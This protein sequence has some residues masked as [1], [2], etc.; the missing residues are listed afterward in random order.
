MR[1]VG[2]AEMR[3]I[4][5]AAIDGLGIPSLELMERAGRAAADAARGLAGPGGRFAV[6][7]GGGNNGGDGWVVARLLVGAGRAVRVVSLV[8]AARLTQDARAER[9]RAEAAGVVAEAADAPLEAG[10]GDVV[11]DAIFGTGL[12][13]APEGAFAAAISRI[14][15][16][17]RAG[18]RVLAVD[19]PSGLSADTGQPL[20]EA[21]VRADRTVTF[22]FQKR[23]LVLHPGPAHAGEVTVADIGIPPE[24]AAQ[25]P[26]EA[27]LLVEDEAR[28]LV[29][30]RDPEAHKGDAGRV[31]VIAG[32]PGKTGAAHLALTGALRGGAG[33]VTLAARAEVLPMALAGRPEAMSAALPGAGPLD[34]SDLGP[35]LEAAAA[36]DA[37]VIGPGIPRGDGTG[38]LLLELLSRAG[39]PA[40][41]DADALNAVAGQAE[42]LAGAGVPLLLTPHPG[43]MARLCGLSTAEVQRDRIGLAARQASAWAA[44]VVL[45]G[46]RTV[47]ADP[48]GP[49]AVIPTGNPGMATG[50]TGDVL[51]GLCGAL[52][53]AGLA[54]GAAGR[55]GAW[56]HGRAGDLAARRLGERGLLASDLGAAIGEVWAE[57][58]R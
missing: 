28:A 5:R 23:G 46:A 42:R 11:V 47:V 55:A 38:A 27:E 36:A 13:R 48:S 17:R 14:E 35:L 53:A 10:P 6:V 18:A 51:A 2:A 9:A 31:L 3:A 32:S 30:P 41:L 44:T 12:S 49:P 19:V 54:P 43:E 33:L 56:V 37:L 20:G 8:D 45:K 52:L 58:R 24:A 21:C 26:A 15:A 22:A 40:V 1:L 25:V 7:C 50:G 39:L 57:C 4:D 29:P 34:A 16:A